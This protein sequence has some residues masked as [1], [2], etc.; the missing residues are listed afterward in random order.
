MQPVPQ[1][2]LGRRATYDDLLEIPDHVVS[3][4]L[5]GELFTSPRPAPRHAH[6]QMNLSSALHGPF[7]RGRGGPGGWRI[8][9][10]P[11]LHVG[12]DV[13][14]PDVAGWL[15]ERMPRL[16]E[17]DYFSTAPDWVCEV[18]S[19]STTTFDRT[20]KLPIYARERVAH[21]WLVDPIAR[22]LEILRLESGRWSFSP[23]TLEPKRCAPSH[24]MR[25]ILKSACCGGK[26]SPQPEGVPSSRS[27]R[28]DSSTSSETTAGSSKR[29]S[30]RSAA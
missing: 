25:S 11:E 8:L 23:R 15:R 2:P 9:T 29:C 28:F 1:V 20:R 26:R 13:V 14:V 12:Q 18:L 10:E 24:S 22:T 30:W 3:E 17:T 7:D 6:A 27:C 16:P 21:C 5:D 4:I 19:P